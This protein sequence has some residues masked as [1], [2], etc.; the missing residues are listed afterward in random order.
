MK[1]VLVAYYS[2][3]GKTETM[4][5]YIAEGVRL[6]GNVVE[7]KKIVD[8]KSEKDLEG[9]DGYIFGCPTYHKSMTRNFETFLFLAEKAGLK[10]KVGGAFGSSTHSG[11]APG[12]IFDTMEHVFAMDMTNLGPFDLRES[13]VDSDE[14]RK[15]CQD[16]GRTLG[17]ML[18]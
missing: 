16:Y 4:G 6:S 9:F 8:I 5:E 13:G 3:T 7:M 1:K 2:R 11:E 18:N 12:V 15:A 17:T 10:G 14:G